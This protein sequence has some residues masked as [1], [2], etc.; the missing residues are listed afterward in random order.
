MSAVGLAAETMG[1]GVVIAGGGTGGHLFPGLAL[2]ETL[3]ARRRAVESTFVGTR[4]R[5]RGARRAEARLPAPSRCPG[6]RSAGGARRARGPRRFQRAR[7]VG[8][9]WRTPRR[10]P[11][12]PRGRRR[13]LRV[14]RRRGSRPGLRGIPT[15]LLEQNAIP[16]VANRH[17]RPRSPPGVRRLR[18]ERR[19]T[20]RA[21][22]RSTRATRS[23]PAASR[24][25][26]TRT[27]VLGCSSSAA[28]RARA[29]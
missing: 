7:G 13:R 15:V 20:S 18:R 5:H 8:A 21:T 29:A 11:A 6:A 12:R 19:R 10:A 2:A 25:R 23:A 3:V 26:A 22:R 1:L 28:A 27:R 17:A 14:G 9:A 4:G 24:R 16:G